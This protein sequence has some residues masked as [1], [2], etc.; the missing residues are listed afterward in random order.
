MIVVRQSPSKSSGVNRT[1]LPPIDIVTQMVIEQD[2]DEHDTLDQLDAGAG[3][4]IVFYDDIEIVEH[5]TSSYSTE[6]DSGSSSHISSRHYSKP[7]TIEPAPPI[8]ARTLKPRHLIAYQTSSSAMEKSRTPPK[9]VDVNSVNDM[10]NRTDFPIGPSSSHR[11]PS[12]RHFVGKLN[13]D[14]LSLT[15]TNGYHRTSNLPARSSSAVRPDE[16]HRSVIADTDALV[17]H[18]QNSLTRNSLH[19]QRIP[20]NLSTSSKDLR[21]FVSATYS[22]SGENAM[23]DNG[24]VHQRPPTDSSDDQTFK[25]QARLSKSFHNV[26]EYKTTDRYPPTDQNLPS[27]SVENN[28]NRVSQQPPKPVRIPARLPSVVNSTSSS[29]LLDPEDNPRMLSMKWYTG[30]VSENSEIGLEPPNLNAD[31][32]LKGYIAAHSNRET[33]VLLDRLRASTDAR[34]HLALDD[35]RSRVAQFDTSKTRDDVQVFMRYL[36]S[37]LRDLSSNTSSS[38]ASLPKQQANGKKPQL[39][40]LSIKSRTS[41]STTTGPSKDTPPSR[42]VGRQQLRSAG[43]NP[44]QQPVPPRRGSQ[45]SANVE[46]ATNIDEM[47]NTVLALPKKSVSGLPSLHR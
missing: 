16:T 3:E 42:Q 12:A 32:L 41:S 24:R 7:T 10:L 22:P 34:I 2:E 26:S 35:I 20:T 30:H 14:D 31:D 45:S 15:V 21:T 44:S 47:L 46:N 23:D 25:R 6:S 18:I 13:N 1:I 33:Q 5:S 28:L 40:T 37:R 4:M 43:G 36:E 8:P 29:A 19:D 11:H 39:D 17:K 38:S 27:K 9:K